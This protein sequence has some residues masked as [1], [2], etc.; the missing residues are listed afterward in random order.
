MIRSVSSS[1]A[2][3]PTFGSA[4]A[5]SPF[6]SLLPICSLIGA[7][8]ERSA[9]RSVLATMNSTPSRPVPTIRLT[10]LLPPPPIPMTLIRAAGPSPSSRWSRSG[11]STRLSS[12]SGVSYRSVIRHSFAHSGR[13]GLSSEEFLEQTTEP[14]GHTAE[15]PRAHRE[16]RRVADKVPVCIQHQADAGGKRRTVHVVG[17]PTDTGGTAAPDGQ[18][19]DLLGDLGHPVEDGAAAGQRD[20]GIEALLVSRPPDLVPHQMEDFLGARLE[21]FGENTPRHHSR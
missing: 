4:P 14:A 11:R 16:A 8:L 5:P 1:A 20:P 10:A 3:R 18:I 12:A 9:C 6:V 7:L 2:E 13:P 17:Q 15:R 19:E 21:D